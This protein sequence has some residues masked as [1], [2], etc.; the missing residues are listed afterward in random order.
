MAF[1][2]GASAHFSDQ[3][4]MSALFMKYDKNYHALLSDGFGETS[5]TQNESGFY[6]GLK[7]LPVKFVQFSAYT[8]FYRSK[9]IN[10]T[11]SGPST[12]WDIFTQTDF[13]FS[14][15]FSFYIRYKNE[16]KY[17]KFKENEREINYPEQTRKT[18]LH[19]QIRPGEKL[20]LKTRLEHVLYSGLEKEN[21]FMIF[22]DFQFQSIQKPV[23]FSARIAYFNTKSYNA[24][25]YAYENDL[26]YTFSIPAYFG[27]GVR[28]YFNIKYRFSE[29]LDFWIKAGNTFWNDRDI[30]GSGYTEIEGKNKTELKFQLR[31]KM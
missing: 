31:L 15:K 18:R 7:L 17:Q 25:I 26:L 30:T 4:S 10:Y 8:D 3:F 23:G 13:V 11:T 29:R 2:Q 16:E 9:W 28:A 6:F 24:R 12:G 14:D 21:G 22:Q 20:A 5:N 27:K 19:F 1:I